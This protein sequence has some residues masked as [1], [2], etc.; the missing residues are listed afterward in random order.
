MA[1]F[2]T[3]QAQMAWRE[4][5]YVSGR[6]SYYKDTPYGFLVTDCKTGGD[7]S[8]DRTLTLCGGKLC[9]CVGMMDTT[10]DWTD[11]DPWQET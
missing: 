1:D 10:F 11:T 9:G 8:R 2:H 5:D 3:L 4:C 7:R 6:G